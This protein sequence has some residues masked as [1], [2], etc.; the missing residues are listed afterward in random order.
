MEILENHE[1]NIEGHTHK[2]KATSFYL[3]AF[4]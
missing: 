4:A 1:G 3:V 2:A